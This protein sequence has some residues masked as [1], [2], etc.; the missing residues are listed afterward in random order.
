MNH[1]A[2][3]PKEPQASISRCPGPRKTLAVARS[4]AVLVITGG[5]TIL[6]T[7][8]KSAVRVGSEK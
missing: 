8:P 4:V 1:T 7:L 3:A 5:L 6:L 2:L